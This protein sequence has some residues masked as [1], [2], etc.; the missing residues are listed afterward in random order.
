MFPGRR[1]TR[2]HLLADPD[3]IPCPIDQV[4]CHEQRSSEPA[5][6]PAAPPPPS[7]PPPYGAGGG[8]APQS[9]PNYLVQAILVTIFCCLP[10]GIVA[11][12]FAA[13]VNGKL[14]AGDYQGAVAASKTAKTW[15]W[16]S[17]GLGAGVALIYL[18]V[19]VAAMATSN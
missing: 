2:S 3:Q 1:L 11:I 18:V 19:L 5:P 17:F 12:V 13:Q 9:V 7:A 16:V 4:R 14:Q 6:A 10:A 8:M 15:T